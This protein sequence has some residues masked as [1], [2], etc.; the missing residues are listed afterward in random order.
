LRGLKPISE[1]FRA[2]LGVAYND[3]ADSRWTYGIAGGYLQFN[4]ARDNAFLQ[5]QAG[6]GNRQEGGFDYFVGK[7]GLSHA[8]IDKRLYIDA[9]FQPIRVA[10]VEQNLGKLGVGLAPWTP[11]YVQIHYYA[12]LFGGDRDARIWSG[13]LDYTYKSITVFGGGS[14]ST[15]TVDVLSAARGL[16]PDVSSVEYFVGVTLPIKKNALTI[17]FNNLDQENAGRKS[18]IAVWKWSLGN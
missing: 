18:V 14:T 12:N 3:V 15:E 8:L 2:E 17:V 4:E 16:D 13:R 1:S 7:T 10:E 9:E 6:R 5:V 11:L